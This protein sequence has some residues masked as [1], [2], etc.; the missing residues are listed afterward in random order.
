MTN[1]TR[2]VVHGGFNQNILHDKAFLKGTKSY[3]V[4]ASKGGQFGF[5][6]TS[7]HSLTTLRMLVVM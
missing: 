2:E 4:D 3:G 1:W 5:M 7:V 6:V